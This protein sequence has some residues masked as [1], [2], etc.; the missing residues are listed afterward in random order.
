MKILVTGA[1]GFIGRHV[2]KALKEACHETI[3]LDQEWYRA[4]D[5]AQ[6][7]TKPLAPIPGLDAVIHLAA[8]ANPRECDGSPS[9]AF[10]VNVHGTQNVL[11]MAVASGANKVVFPSSGHVYDMPPLYLPTDEQHPLRLN[12]TYTIT[13]ILG[14]QLCELY[15]QNHGLSYTTLR[16][17][18]AYGPG[19]QLGYF[20]PDM[21]A[22]KGDISLGSGGHITKDWVWVEE[23]ADAFVKA[24]SSPFV[25]AVNIGTGIET[26]LYVIAGRIV[27][28]KGFVCTVEAA[29]NP[30]RMR[31]DNSRAQRVLDWQPKVS[32]EDGLER[33]LQARRSKVMA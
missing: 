12:N 22:K 32:I 6:D 23:V 29:D 21:L 24:I 2:V 31:A 8:I 27:A 14:E 20:I 15:Y 7:I 19:Q 25:G 13:K 26:P 3:T 5:I 33:I 17:Y 1:N 30:S 18:N 16:L 28:E 9:R 4:M 10:D 11:K